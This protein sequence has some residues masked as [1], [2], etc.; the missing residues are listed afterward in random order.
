MF[1]LCSSMICKWV[2]SH[3]PPQYPAP[4]YP[5]QYP[6]PSVPILFLMCFLLFHPSI[7]FSL[8]SFTPLTQ[9][10]RQY[11][12][13][14]L[15]VFSPHVESILQQLVQ[16]LLSPPYRYNLRWVSLSNLLNPPS[17]KQCVIIGT[18][19]KQ[20]QLKPNILR[21]LSED[22]NLPAK[23]ERKRYVHKT[24]TLFLEDNTQR[25]VL[26]GAISP[27]VCPHLCLKWDLNVQRFLKSERTI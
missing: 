23:P 6:P 11:P 17:G 8:S 22:A 16:V 9:Y 1:L 20:M 24:D 3:Y 7:V 2:S 18:L 10:P 26:T 12:S 19:F 27:K 5:P 13:S 25:I 15:I 21:E 4:Q 14:F